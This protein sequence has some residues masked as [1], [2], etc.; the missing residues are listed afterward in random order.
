[1]DEIEKLSINIS[2]FS[3]PAEYR[4]EDYYTQEKPQFL[5]FPLLN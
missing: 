3:Q 1:M 2:P 4:V 5:I